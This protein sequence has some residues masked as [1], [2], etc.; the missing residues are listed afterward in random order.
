[1]LWLVAGTGLLTWGACGIT[2]RA[3]GCPLTAEAPAEVA[4]PPPPRPWLKQKP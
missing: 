1:M 4:L 2:F 3:L